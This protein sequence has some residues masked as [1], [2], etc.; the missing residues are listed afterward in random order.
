MFSQASVGGDVAH[1][2]TSRI[3]TC[4]ATN[5][6]VEGCEK[7][8]AESRVVLLFATKS[9]RVAGFTGPL[10]TCPAA[11]DVTHVYGRVTHS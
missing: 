4:L 1:F 11:R 2:T 7:F 8:V 5:Q 3:Q 6:V 9:I 10:Q